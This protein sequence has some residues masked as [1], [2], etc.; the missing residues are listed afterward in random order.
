MKQKLMKIFLFLLIEISSIA[1]ITSVSAAATSGDI[2]TG[3]VVAGGPF[4]VMHDK[5]NGHRMWLTE[6]FLIRSSDGAYVYCVQPYV[7]IKQDN[8]YNV[9]T[10]DYASV[11]G[12]SQDTWSVISKI[13]YYG[14][15]YKDATHDHS[16]EKWYAAAQMLIWN[17]VNP[18][19]DSFFTDTL[20]GTR[21]DNILKAEQNEI[22]DLV[23]NHN[24]KPSFNNIPEQMVIG[25][26]ITITDTKGV[27]SN[28]EVTDVKGATI[29]K[30]GNDLTITATEVGN[31]SFKLVKLGNRYGEPVRLYYASDSQNVIRRGN[32]DP[33]TLS[34]SIKVIGGKVSIQ[35]T[36]ADTYEFIPQGEATLGGAKY[37]IYKEDGTRVGEIT[38]NEEGKATS[39]YLPSLGTFY[40]LEEKASTGYQ[41]DKNK[42]EFFI[43]QNDLNPEVQ[44][45]EKVIE[46]KFD[47]TKVYAT[48]KTAIM[49]PEVGIKFGAYN[50]KNELVGV[51]TTDEQ[52]NFEV[53]LPYGTYTVKQLTTTTGHEKM[54]DFNI[55]VKEVGNTIK[56]TIS[57]AEITAKLRVVKIDS[58]TK[59]VIKRSGIKFKI[60]DTKTN[61]EVCQTITYPTSQT[62]CTFETNNNGE[63]ITAYPLNTGTYKLQE[64]DQVIDG[65]LWN[66]ESLDFTID[67]NSKLRDD[68]EYGII[69]DTNFEN[70]P[71]KG[72]VKIEKVGEVVTLTE[73]GYTF[74]KE[75]LSGITFGLYQN[76]KEI[77]TGKTD[78]DGNLIF[79][80]LKLGKYCIKEIKTLDGY[81]LNDKQICFE[82]KYKDQ[83]TP[84][85][86]YKTLVENKLKTSKL[87][88][89]KQDIST[90]E[91]LPNTTIEIYTNKDELVYSGK[92][93]EEGK[94]IIERLPIGK[95]YFVETEAPEGYLI[96]EEKMYFEVTGEEIVKSTIKDK[97]ITGTLEFTKTDFSESVTLPNTTIEIYN[98]KDELIFTGKTNE[99]GMIVIEELEYGKYY[100]L[101]KEAPKGYTLNTEKM[102]FE[103]KENGEVVKCNM[104]D[105]EIIEVPNTEAN[106]FPF[107]ELG[108]LVLCIVGFGVLIY[109][110]KKKK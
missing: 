53:K 65:Y 6:K 32:V 23:N 13:A 38:T 99:N 51:Y 46:R 84:V 20:K 61:K 21:N 67:E 83:Y 9:T 22:M 86:T 28:F 69:F 17:K 71:V 90:E 77:A 49:T 68:S 44:V 80:D 45:F 101:E 79:N 39:D 8:T 12:I 100:I 109:A 110:N 108:S 31:M 82:L 95:Y 35:K 47:F 70:K 52:G 50:N 85:I 18:S 87:E 74:T 58:E 104:K 48:D 88:I 14:Y 62:I 106:E 24:V 29:T 92:T 91:S 78:K 97:K 98:D 37:G 42:Y 54:N 59:E 93:N 34:N 105:E 2:I 3:K 36:D 107:L 63:F 25:E 66:S 15:Q 19:I 73:E 41:L 103:I 43:T 102:Y 4:Y 55:E 96:N 7:T 75:S 30:N 26:S 27:L 81:I 40:L 94:I 33:V 72:E 60:I 56:K 1:R 76:N 57:N 64:I 16:A 11:L 89:T 10:E 5:K